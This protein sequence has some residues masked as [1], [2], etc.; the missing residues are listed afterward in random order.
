MSLL[1]AN[2]KT[3]TATVNGEEQEFPKLSYADKAAILRRALRIR[4]ESERAALAI[5]GISM[6]D[7][8]EQ[9]AELEREF[10][11]DQAFTDYINAGE[12]GDVLLFILAKR[13][14]ILSG[15]ELKAEA[16]TIPKPLEIVMQCCNLHWIEKKNGSADPLTGAGEN[17]P[18]GENTPMKPTDLPTTGPSTATP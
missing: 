7:A 17:P 16:V 11:G 6:D 13:N 8:D 15:D 10:R 4:K 2:S 18:A 12:W 14:P 1:D 5:D 9:M 3:I